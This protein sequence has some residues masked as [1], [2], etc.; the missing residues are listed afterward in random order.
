MITCKSICRIIVCLILLASPAIAQDVEKE[1]AAIA[2]AEQWLL[3]VDA[4]KYSESWK[5]AAELF[6]NAVTQEQWSQ[7]LKAARAP[8]GRLVSRELDSKLYKTSLPGAPDGE[9]VVIQF[10]TSFENKKTSVET[11]TPI[12]EKDGRWRVSGYYIK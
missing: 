5:E 9:Y 6:R 4:V 10:R 8:L 1:K 3:L 2:A 12:L 7:S 11:I